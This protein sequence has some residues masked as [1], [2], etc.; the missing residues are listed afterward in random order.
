MEKRRQ[1]YQ[2]GFQYELLIGYI[3]PGG[4]THFGGEL[5]SLLDIETGQAIRISGQPTLAKWRDSIRKKLL[6]ATKKLSTQ[7]RMSEGDRERL[8]GLMDYIE[9]APTAIELN[10]AVKELWP[11]AKRV[12][13]RK[14]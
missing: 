10:E 8:E 11:I 14:W 13:D 5:Q 12:I 7:K 6:R 3:S 1:H 9:K 4:E 2:D